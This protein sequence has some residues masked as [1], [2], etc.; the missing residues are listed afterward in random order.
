[1]EA[2]LWISG[3]ILLVLWLRDVLQIAYEA[4]TNDGPPEPVVR[5]ARTSYLRSRTDPW[6]VVRLKEWQFD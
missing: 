4:F 2:I 5:H 3:F 6:S 1:M